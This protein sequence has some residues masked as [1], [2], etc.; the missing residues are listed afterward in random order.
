[1]TLGIPV[2]CFVCFLA[3]SS[4]AIFAPRRPPAVSVRAAAVNWPAQVDA[5]AAGAGVA[6]RLALARELGTCRGRWARDTVAAA[7]AE[8][9]DAAVGAALADALAAIRAR[10][11]QA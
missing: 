10:A 1:M 11:A 2:A 7:L 6:V 3:F 9:P 8:E 5:R 4:I